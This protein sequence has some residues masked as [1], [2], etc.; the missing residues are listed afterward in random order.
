M[1]G[2]D[3]AGNLPLTAYEDSGGE[4]KCVLIGKDGK[5]ARDRNGKPI[6]WPLK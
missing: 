6:T 2:C 1:N 4:K 3:T 5:S